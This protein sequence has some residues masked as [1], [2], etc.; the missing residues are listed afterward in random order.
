MGGLDL[1]N[2]FIV[3]GTDTE[4]GKTVFS[5]MLTL[6]LKGVYWKPI[7]SGLEELSDTETVRRMTGLSLGHFLP[8]AYRLNTPASPHYSAELDDVEIDVSRLDPAKLE[9]EIA[10]APM[11]IEGA[12]GLLV[13]I[14]RELLTIDLFKSWNMPVI[15]CARTSL[16]TINHSLLSV[17][18]LKARD[19][20]IAGI[21]FIGDENPDNERT[22][23]EFAGVT[24][25][26]R[27]PRLPELDAK[28]LRETFNNHFKLGEFGAFL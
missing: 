1:T 25:L 28:N 10:N 2:G 12:G 6:A 11:I 13:P 22:I 5:A 21:V 26:G 3:S 4:I 14:T 8:E 18:A 27:L 7:Q 19:M 17:E 20:E 23:T 16:G 24:N 15:L 9:P